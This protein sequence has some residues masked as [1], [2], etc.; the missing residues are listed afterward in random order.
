M[1]VNIKITHPTG[2]I[3]EKG[4]WI[5][6]IVRH[7]EQTARA[8]PVVTPIE[9]VG[10]GLSVAEERRHNRGFNFPLELRNADRFRRIAVLA[11]YVGID[12]FERTFGGYTAADCVDFAVLCKGKEPLESLGQR[13]VVEFYD[14]TKLLHEVPIDEMHWRHHGVSLSI[15]GKRNGAWQQLIG[16]GSRWVPQEPFGGDIGTYC[17]QL[18]AQLRKAEQGPSIFTPDTRAPSR[19]PAP[20]ASSSPRAAPAPVPAVTLAPVP[21]QVART[22]VAGQA[23]TEPVSRPVKQV[24]AGRGQ[25]KGSKEDADRSMLR[26]FLGGVVLAALVFSVAYWLFSAR[27]A[28]DAAPAV[29]RAA[30]PVAA[31][32]VQAAP[33]PV[34]VL[35]PRDQLYEFGYKDH[36]KNVLAAV[37]AM[38][39]GNRNAMNVSLNWLYQ[40][41]PAVQPEALD[42]AAQGAFRASI[43]QQLD[44]AGTGRTELLQGISDQLER[45]L[46]GNFSQAWAQA[47]LAQVKIL[48]KEPQPALRPAFHAIVYDPHD[49]RG[50]LLLGT[51]LAMSKDTAGAANSFC[52]GI[53][54]SGFT[55]QALGMLDSLETD[56]S[57]GDKVNAAARKSRSLCPKPL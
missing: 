17:N 18:I 13:V 2:K 38:G 44:H 54:S 20:P 30:V 14:G 31:P 25:G 49:A 26:V 43:V 45:F 56:G 22:E 15:A 41:R 50:W 21:A 29:T 3:D 5:G 7:R 12:D 19:P 51:G 10:L 40:N 46:L 24:G 27:K 42:S 33:K 48:L 16:P 39:A 55:D 1:P 47:D 52:V 8:L 36:L 23:T 35:V 34:P 37:K 6:F 9:I 53:E 57:Y 28:S 32:A 11:F 4:F